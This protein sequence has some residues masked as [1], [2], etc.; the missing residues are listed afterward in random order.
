MP[1]NCATEPGN[2]AP[3]RRRAGAAY[4]TASVV[5][6]LGGKLGSM[7]N[8]DGRF[9]PSLDSVAK[10]H[11]PFGVPD[12]VD[13]IVKG[14]S[15][16]IGERVIKTL[17]KTC[18]TPPAAGRSRSARRAGSATSKAV[19]ATMDMFLGPVFERILKRLGMAD[20]PLRASLCASTII[21]LGT[22]RWVVKT[23]RWP[24]RQ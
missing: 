22:M 19:D 13:D 2:S 12:F 18:G 23:E 14:T 20:I 10:L 17:V 7:S 9:V 15:N 21:G 3:R 1:Q 24:A 6:P 11:L 8:D 4:A 5:D 16:R